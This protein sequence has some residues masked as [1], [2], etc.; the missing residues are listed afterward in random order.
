[1]INLNQE[2]Q[3]AVKSSLQSHCIVDSGAGT[4][5]TRVIVERL[6]YLLDN[7]VPPEKIWL[8]TFTNA[9]AREMLSRAAVQHPDSGRVSYSGTFH[10]VAAKLLRQAARHIES[11][12]ASGGANIYEQAVSGWLNS[13]F[14]ILDADEARKEL[15]RIIKELPDDEKDELPPAGQVQGII[16]AAANRRKSV[17]ELAGDCGVIMEKVANEYRKRKEAEGFLDFDDLL[18]NLL[19]L[20]KSGLGYDDL[21]A[22]HVLVDEFQDVNQAQTEILVELARAGAQV[23]AVGDPCQ[24][25]YRFR[26]AEFKTILNFHDIFQGAERYELSTNYRSSDAILSLANDISGKSGL[27]KTLSSGIN[28]PDPIITTPADEEAEASG[29]AEHIARMLDN[30]VP[31]EQICI[32]SKSGRYTRRIEMHLAKRKIKYLKR[33]GL[34]LGRLRCVGDLAAFFRIRIFDKDQVAW[35]RLCEAAKG[36][37]LGGGKGTAQLL[38]EL[39]RFPERRPCTY[40]IVDQDT[41]YLGNKGKKEWRNRQKCNGVCPWVAGAGLQAIAYY[42]PKGKSKEVGEALKRAILQLYAIKRDDPQRV[43][44]MARLAVDWLMVIAKGRYES[45]KLAEKDFEQLLGLAG[46]YATEEE[47]LDSISLETSASVEDSS[48]RVVVS[49]VHSAKGLE[50]DHVFVVGATEDH[51]PTEVGDYEQINELFRLGYVA[52]TRA[53]KELVISAPKRANIYGQWV[54]CCLS[55][56]FYKK[57]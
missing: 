15:K 23:Y 29:L 48:E 36:C 37:G 5:K 4:G 19:R 7:R 51:W 34:Q 21:S 57:A 49:T 8:L 43:Q 42:D 6:V 39:N 16:S 27:P 41:C 17:F 46:E 54:D 33:G 26:G 38:D 31:P 30:G 10:S 11:M 28:G 20:L 56:V 47:F 2:Q 32:L 14:S 40:F 45:A 44:K 18:D 22:Y 52:V 24:S 50:W 9:A 25:I 13:K 55:E 12:V 53:A 1:V 3:E 35:R